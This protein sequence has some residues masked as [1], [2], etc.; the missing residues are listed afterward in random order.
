MSEAEAWEGDGDMF[1]DEEERKH[2][3]SVLDSFR[4]EHNISMLQHPIDV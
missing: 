2:L 3:F 1:A 4:Y